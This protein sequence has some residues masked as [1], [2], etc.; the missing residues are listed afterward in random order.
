LNYQKLIEQF[1][2]YHIHRSRLSLDLGSPS[3]TNYHVKSANKPISV[4]TPTSTNSPSII[5]IN[6]PT[7]PLVANSAPFPSRYT[8]FKTYNST[9][10]GLQALD[11]HVNN[12]TTNANNIC[13]TSNGNNHRVGSHITQSSDNSLTRVSSLPSINPQN[14][15]T[16]K[17]HH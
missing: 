14:Q 5:K 7:S 9:F 15:S 1:N 8:E 13:I 11:S 4:T 12:S 17:V 3:I 6:S 10:D 2:L 16:G